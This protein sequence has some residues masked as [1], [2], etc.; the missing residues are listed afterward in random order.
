[1]TAAD[2]WTAPVTLVGD[3]VRLEPIGAEHLADLV[4][5]GLQPDIWRWSVHAI[6]AADDMH[7][8]V[9]AA[10]AARSAGD[11]LPFATIETR[12]GRVVGS[13]RFMAIVPGHRRLEIGHTW[14]APAWQ[15]TAINTEAKLLM[16]SHA[17]DTLGCVRVEFKTDSLN[18]DS[19]RALLGIGAIEEGTLRSH[20][21]TDSGRRR[22]SVYYSI[23]DDEWP[24]VR[25]RLQARLQAHA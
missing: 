23:L 10:L 1:M 8:Y 12:S 14:L 7:A 2:E 22:D 19:R 4:D 13:T 6:R 17:F 11:E 20:M 18:D 16:L 24:A 15:R 25:V 21:I 3:H 9:D 5:V